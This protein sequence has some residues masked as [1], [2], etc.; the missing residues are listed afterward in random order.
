ML[1][2]AGGG[3]CPSILGPSTKP[4]LLS[5]PWPHPTSRSEVNGPGLAFKMV[6]LPVSL[7]AG[8][9]F[10]T[11]KPGERA[12]QAD[13]LRNPGRR[14]G[15][16]FSAGLRTSRFSEVVVLRGLQTS[17]LSWLTV[18][19]QSWVVIREFCCLSINVLMLAGLNRPVPI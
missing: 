7:A 6:H 12:W 11:K 3:S 14:T 19:F 10:Q 4:W 17:N 5:V 16:Y 13:G 2:G 15:G 18:C 1:T 8:S 9:W